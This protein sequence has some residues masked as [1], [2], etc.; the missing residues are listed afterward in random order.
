MAFAALFHAQAA[1]A[2]QLAEHLRD[3]HAALF[4]NAVAWSERLMARG[5]GPAFVLAAGWR[6]WRQ[7]CLC[8]LGESARECR[9]IQDLS[10]C[11][12]HTSSVVAG[13]CVSTASS[14]VL[15]R[16]R[17]SLSLER[18]LLARAGPSLDVRANR[19]LP[20]PIDSTLTPALNVPTKPSAAHAKTAAIVRV[21]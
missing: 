5:A 7:F 4:L 10:P 2:R 9:F 1:V 19:A 8:K 11:S 18:P 15:F 12:S 14:A 3:R 13:L 20:L 6:E 21:E 17:K 16:A